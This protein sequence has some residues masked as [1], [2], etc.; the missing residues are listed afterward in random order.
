MGKGIIKISYMIVAQW[1]VEGKR[2]E[3]MKS[4]L[5]LP[6]NYEV[7]H[8]HT[9]NCNYLS[10]IVSSPDIPEV[11]EGE[12]YPTVEPVYAYDLVEGGHYKP[13]LLRIDITP[14]GNYTTGEKQTFAFGLANKISRDLDEELDKKIKEGNW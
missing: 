6:E 12:L 4:I 2:Q 1:F 11:P 13:T 3:D 9:E 10:I 7:C 8:M 5:M 14:L